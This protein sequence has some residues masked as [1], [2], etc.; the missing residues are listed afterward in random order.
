MRH[1]YLLALLLAL[2]WPLAARAQQPFESLGV[3]VEILSLTHGR[4][5]EYFDND[6]LRRI[7]SVVYDTRLGRVAYLL[8]PDSLLGRLESDVSARF[9][10]VDPLAEED[11]HISPYAFCRNNALLYSDPDGRKVVFAQGATA[12]FKREFAAAVKYLN[13]HGAGGMLANLQKSKETYTVGFGQ[14]AEGA[15]FSYKDRTITWD[16]R[17]GT[18]TTDAE[19]NKHKLSP[20]NLLNHEADHAN[21]Y[22]KNPEQYQKDRNT[23]DDDYQNKE[24]KRVITG[25]EQDTAHKLGE[26]PAGQVTRNSHDGGTLYPTTGPTSTKPA[27]AEPAKPKEERKP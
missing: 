5:P 10:T 24:E 9:V 14:I 20:S 13:A 3:K 16:P 11:A 17:T 12:Q 1:P 7:G 25:S 4:F 6:S 8:P 26:V 19:G 27:P 22:D 18:T 15:G 23:K 2:G 21:Q